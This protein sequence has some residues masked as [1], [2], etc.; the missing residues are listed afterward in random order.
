[1]TKEDWGKL[2]FG[3]IVFW[4]EH[5]GPS[6]II[7]GKASWTRLPWPNTWIATRICTSENSIPESHAIAGHHSDYSPHSGWQIRSR[8]DLDAIY[9]ISTHK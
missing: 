6:Y 2:K 5:P 8:Q 1:M 4:G 3:T 9:N 7:T